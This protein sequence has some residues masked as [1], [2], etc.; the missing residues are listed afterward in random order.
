[1]G[2]GGVMRAAAKVAGMGALNGGLRGVPTVPAA[3][4]PVA[5][6]ALKASRP[7]SAIASSSPAQ[8][9]AVEMQRSSWDSDDWEFAGVGEEMIL[10]V[11]YPPPRLVFGDVPTLE[12]AKSATADL[13]DALEKDFNSPK[14]AGSMGSFSNDHEPNQPLLSNS[15][16]IKGCVTS[17]NS[18]TP[19]PN[20]AMQ[21]F[22][23]L[24]ENTAAQTVV[25]SI[26][27]DRNV[28]DAVMKNEAL[29]EFFQSQKTNAP[30][31][32]GVM[33]EKESVVDNEDSSVPK[34]SGNVGNAFLG[35]MQDVKHSVVEMVNRASDLFWNVF[36]VGAGDQKS[37]EA[38]MEGM[39][40]F[41]QSP[42]GISIMGLVVM[43]ITVVVM[44]R[45]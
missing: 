19:M 18:V 9:E 10:D 27:S 1:M 28:W 30:S 41:M 7:V 15:S 34:Q 13:T 2:G 31:F 16:E 38:G 44:K 29:A 39:A 17:D 40:S 26:A 3:E 36:G 4:Y 20:H 11:D 37:G 21:A 33:E 35:F 25:A 24:K 42:T 22:K 5:A 14:S 12:E 23:L 32:Y 6:A 43:V 45:V 8:P